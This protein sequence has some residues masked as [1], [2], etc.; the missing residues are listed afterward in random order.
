MA[1]EQTNGTEKPKDKTLE[2]YALT[3]EVA[4][5]FG[6]LTT[7]QSKLSPQ[8]V[9]K[10]K[11]ELDDIY[12]KLVTLQHRV[13]ALFVVPLANFEAIQVKKYAAAQQ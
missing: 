12:E 11:A 2:M 1:N 8:F 13:L 6:T 7:V 9:E 4:S 5:S 10:N 3:A